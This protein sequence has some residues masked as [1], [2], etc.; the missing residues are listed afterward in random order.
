MKFRLL[1]AHYLPGDLYLYG[2]KEAEAEKG[3]EGGS[4]IDNGSVVSHDGKRFSI[5][6]KEFHPTLEM[7][8]LDEEA[9]E[10]L[11][12]EYERLQKN[13][14]VESGVAI[15]PIDQLPKFV[16]NYEARFTP[17]GFVRKKAAIAFAMA[18]SATSASAQTFPMG[19]DAYALDNQQSNEAVASFVFNSP[20]KTMR[21]LTARAT[22]VGFVYLF[23]ATAIASN[24]A[25]NACAS[26]ATARP[27]YVWCVPLA[28][29]AYTF[30]QWDSPIQFSTGIV[31]AYSSTGC[32]SFTASATA[33]FSGQTP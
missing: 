12:E 3:L 7:V 8:A 22:A 10:A 23:D 24:G 28:A 15:V 20:K 5:D 29:N 9:E 16:E 18:L 17:G 30:M 13:Q 19:L 25:V 27:C 2:D 21:T 31:A 33:Q 14:N 6:M 4:I 11:T 26:A 32:A 1:S